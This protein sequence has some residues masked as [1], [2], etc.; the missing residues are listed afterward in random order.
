MQAVSVTTANND[1]IQLWQN[2]SKINRFSYDRHSF[3]WSASVEAAANAA[4]AV[5]VIPSDSNQHV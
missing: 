1:V 5:A 4:A 2:M 3:K